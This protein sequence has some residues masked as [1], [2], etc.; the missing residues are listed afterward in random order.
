VRDDTEGREAL[1]PEGKFLPSIRG[2][3]EL[4]RPSLFNNVQCP[5]PLFVLNV[6]EIHVR[7]NCA[8]APVIHT[9]DLHKFHILKPKRLFATPI[10]VTFNK[11]S[12][13]CAGSSAKEKEK[14]NLDPDET[15]EWLRVIDPKCVND[16]VERLN[17]H[18]ML[19]F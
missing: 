9:T 1:Q 10:A 5:A 18:R 17:V 2:Q 6:L 15:R 4:V 7:R 11:S 14:R 16:G 3:S 12:G 8:L 13:P 19:L